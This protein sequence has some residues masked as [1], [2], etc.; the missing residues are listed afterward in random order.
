M[1]IHSTSPFSRAFDYASDHIGLR[2][3]NPLYRITELLTGWKFRSSL[4]IVKGFGQQI[5]TNA[6]ANR[7]KVERDTNSTDTK[8]AYGSLIGSLMDTFEDTSIVADA[9]LNFLSA[10]RDTTAQSLTWT[11][12]LLMRHPAV[13]DRIRQE[14]ASAFPPAA[15]QLDPCAVEIADLQPNNLPYAMAV[16]YEALRLYPPVPFEIKQCE[17]DVTLPDGTFLPAGSIVVWCVWAMNRSAE[18]WVDQ[19][20]RLASFDPSRWLQDGKLITKSAFDFPVF[21]GG[22]RLC[23]GKK[24]AELMAAYMIVKLVR[25]F[26]F[27]EIKDKKQPE[28]QRRTQ[29]SLTLPMEGGLPCRARFVQRASKA[30]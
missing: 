15:Q 20:S 22:T 2:F 8:V 12:Y 6:S 5:V 9:A 27:E 3:Q 14:I 21:N 24:M 18:I 16:F 30:G 4:A 23:L 26:D 17:V 11:F 25:E 13:L 19:G 28:K 7:A 10:G 29:N 1:E